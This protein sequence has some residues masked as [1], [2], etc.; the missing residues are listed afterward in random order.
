[1]VAASFT[2]DDGQTV[3]QISP[4][5]VYAKAAWTQ[6]IRL[7]D[8]SGNALTGSETVQAA[9]VETDSQ[10]T[11]LTDTVAL[12][13]NG[14]DTELWDLTIPAAET[15]KLLGLEDVK[16]EVSVDDVKRHFKLSVQDSAI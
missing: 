12:T 11:A 3:Y 2:S 16:L 7:V 13:Q 5:D 6:Q 15:A 14:T 10:S 8:S 1:M 9:F 4:A